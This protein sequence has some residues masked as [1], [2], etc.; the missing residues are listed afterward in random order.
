MNTHRM[1]RS[2]RWLLTTGLL[3]TLVG[4]AA[5]VAQAASY[6][7]NGLKEGSL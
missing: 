4:P 7:I 1:N 5:S 6:V 3:L 2:A